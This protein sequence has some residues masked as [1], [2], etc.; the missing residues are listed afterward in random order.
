VKQLVLPTT[1]FSK[2]G[3]TQGDPLSMFGYGIGILPLICRLKE[4]SPEVKQPWYAD[5]RV[6]EAASPICASSLPG[7]KKIGPSYGDF[8][9]PLQSI[10]VVR[11]LS[12]TTVKKSAFADFGFNI[13]TGY[14]YLGGFIG[15][16]DNQ[17]V[18]IEGKVADWRSVIADLT[19]VVLSHP[20]SAYS[21]LQKYL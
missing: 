9:E 16:T 13:Q 15:S 10:L 5:K 18:W 3:V 14:C 19:F 12:R 6:P 1:L 21:G 2:E 4:E 11:E 7:F 17:M 8:L 20:Q